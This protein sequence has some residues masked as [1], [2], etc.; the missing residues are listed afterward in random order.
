[1]EQLRQRLARLLRDKMRTSLVDTQVKVAAKA[2]I[3]QSTVQRLLTLEQAATVDLLESLAKAFGVKHPE[4]LLLDPDDAKLLSLWSTLSEEDRGTVLGFIQMKAQTKMVHDAPP[5][6]NFETKTPVSQD[7]RAASK[8]ASVRKPASGQLTK[9][10][11]DK[12]NTAR[13][14]R[15]A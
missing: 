6:L 2:G 11:D 7:M 15:K 8:R 12:N 14:R 1:M 5:Q 3:S 13:T 9:A 10:A 4:Y